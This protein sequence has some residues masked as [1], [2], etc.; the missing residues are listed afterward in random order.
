MFVLTSDGRSSGFHN[1]HPW[2]G[3]N[4]A[5]AIHIERRAPDAQRL[6]VVLSEWRAA[7]ERTDGV[8]MAEGDHR[9]TNPKTGEIIKLRNDGGDAEVFF[10]VE[11][12]WRR[13]FYWSP[14]GRISFRAPRDFL[15]PTSVIRRLALKLA[16]D[17]DAVLV[18]DEREMYD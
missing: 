10:T 3:V 2:L 4:M 11:A 18:G 15:E 16:R 12:S 5:Y 6:P 9:I 1:Q 17:L 7:V 14:P 13:V 8:R